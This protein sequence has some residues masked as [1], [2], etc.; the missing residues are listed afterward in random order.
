VIQEAQ[1]Q[2]LARPAFPVEQRQLANGLRVVVQS[3]PSAPLVAALMC[4]DAGSRRDPAGRSG[5]A[6]MFEHLAFDGPRRGV[7][8]TFPGRVEYAGGSGQAVTLTDRLCFLSFFPRRELPTILALEAER[9]ARPLD[10]HDDEAL[11]VQRRVVLEELR[12]RSQRRLRALAFE[13]A[14]RLLFQA[15]HAYHHPPVGEPDDIRAVAPADLAA[16]AERFTPARA[17]LVL[18]GDV[19]PDAAAQ[20]AER[21]FGGL[22]AS[23]PQPSSES[24]E[25]GATG[26]PRY[27]LM[28]APVSE[29]Q[30][31]VA[32]RVPGFGQSDWYHAALLMR[33]L[34]VGRASPLSRVLVGQAGLAREVSGHLIPMRDASTLVFAATG[35]R[36]VDAARLEQGLTETLVELSSRTLESTDLVRA[37]KKALGD[38]YFAA[39]S[40]ERRSE[41]CAALAWGPGDPERLSSEPSRYLEPDAASVGAVAA[42]L[43]Q[44]HARASVTFVPQ[45]VA[46]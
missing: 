37:K 10:P 14:N 25:D 12:E 5:M 34:A 17:V 29:P 36:G 38:Y 30:V 15:G 8:R 3:D 43:L 7:A 39:Q 23:G 1:L 13:H 44:A 4:Y 26:Q 41:M 16:F 45:A 11:D 21:C 19:T 18:V 9:M 35:A 40:F 6:H 27:V 33:A 31:H 24:P 28:P 22:S 20:I 42:R 46:A 32:W 2:A